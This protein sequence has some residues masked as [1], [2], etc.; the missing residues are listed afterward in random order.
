MSG[1]PVLGPI[2]FVCALMIYTPLMLNMLPILMIGP[3]CVGFSLMPLYTAR[4][5]YQSVIL[6]VCYVFIVMTY[7]SVILALIGWLDSFFHFRK[8][9]KEVNL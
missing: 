2:S 4:F 5:K 8:R 1:N 9:M 6:F 7:L 3:A